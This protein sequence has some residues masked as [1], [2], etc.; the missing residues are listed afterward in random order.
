MNL[1]DAIGVGCETVCS[2]AYTPRAAKS[3]YDAVEEQDANDLY[4][5][6][7]YEWSL[8]GGHFPVYWGSGFAVDVPYLLNQMDRDGKPDD[9]MK[10]TALALLGPGGDRNDTSRP[11]VR[12]S[13]SAWQLAYKVSRECRGVS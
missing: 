3:V 2:S 1:N 6:D 8:L 5:E 12:A 9:E 11:E 10:K 4:L 7:M 13:N